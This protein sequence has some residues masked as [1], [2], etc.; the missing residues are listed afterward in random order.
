M[1]DTKRTQVGVFLALVIGAI[2]ACL[3]APAASQNL[4]RYGLYHE[5]EIFFD[6]DVRIDYSKKEEAELICVYSIAYD[7]LRFIKSGESY[8]SRFDFSFIIYD[9]D[10]SQVTGDVWRHRVVA[11]DYETTTSFETAYSGT[12]RFDLGVGEF[13]YVATVT[14]INSGETGKIESKLEIED[15]SHGYF[16]L[17]DPVFERAATPSDSAESMDFVP[18][19]SH[20][21]DEVHGR[22]R[23]T[24]YLYGPDNPEPVSYEIS[25]VV[26]NDLDEEVF[27]I[28]DTLDQQG[29]R[30]SY[31]EEVLVAAWAVGSYG[32]EIEATELTKGETETA[33]GSVEVLTSLADWDV[34]YSDMLEKI[35]YIA[36]RQEMSELEDSPPEE[37]RR[38]WK[39]FWKKRDPTPETARNEYQIEYFRRIRYANERFTTFVEGWKT[40][41][42]RIYIQYGDPDMV[43]SE[44]VGS[45]MKSWE[46]WYYYSLR[47]R[48]IFVD[49]MG[50]GE[51]ELV[52]S[53]QL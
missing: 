1:S 47:T 27:S 43:D 46:I 5:G 16:G 28:L 18:N 12:E 36:S 48:F 41:M 44:A 3:F 15:M 32:I 39:E 53:D 50:F 30:S 6:L 13:E 31:T 14:D 34:G 24:F 19:P 26:T 42:G 10:G 21:Y 33:R 40:D 7:Q 49:E 17:S 52:A 2:V 4:D 22:M 51:Y 8:T 25:I 37:R 45:T 29:W 11:Q 20:S 38:K 9:D 35:E 23:M